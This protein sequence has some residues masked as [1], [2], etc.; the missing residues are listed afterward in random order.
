MITMLCAFISEDRNIECA[1]DTDSFH[2]IVDTGASAAFTLCKQDIISFTPMN[3]KVKGLATLQVAGVGTVQYRVK[4]DQGETINL[5]IDNCYYVPEMDIHLICPQQLTKQIT[6]PCVQS[7]DDKVFHLHWNGNTKM[8]PISKA[9]NLPIL[10]T[11]PGVLNR[12]QR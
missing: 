9:N 1:F 7:F 2:I 11:A 8:I 5:I 6:M 3:K 10:Y 12:R 4:N